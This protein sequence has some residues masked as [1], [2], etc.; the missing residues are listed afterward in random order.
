[1]YMANRWFRTSHPQPMI[2]TPNLN[3]EMQK[4][5]LWNMLA[6]T[7]FAL[8]IAWFRYDLERVSQKINHLH[9]QKAARYGS[10]AMALP[11]MFLFQDEKLLREKL[12]Q[13][14]YMVAGYIAVWTIYIGYLLF[15]FAKLKRLQREGAAVGLGEG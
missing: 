11:L 8:L 9:I 10:M 5:L 6:F 3:P 4:V 14:H 13:H 2:G 7:L 15:L 1:V 12:V